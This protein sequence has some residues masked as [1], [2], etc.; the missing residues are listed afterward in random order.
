MSKWADIR[1]KRLVTA[2]NQQDVEN[3]RDAMRAELRLAELRKHRGVTQETIAGVLSV[4]QPNVSQIEHGDDVKLS[5]LQTYV[6]ALGGTLRIEAVFE[7]DDVFR[8]T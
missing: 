3:I 5:T 6:R 4:T 2:E 8:I 1:A 7:D